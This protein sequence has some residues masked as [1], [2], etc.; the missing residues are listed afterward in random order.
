MGLLDLFSSPIHKKIDRAKGVMLN[1]HHQAQVRQGAIHELM[2]Y[3]TPAAIEALVE[4]LGVS[5]RDTIQNEHEQGWVHDL[6]VDHFKERAVEPLKDFIARG[7]FVSRAILT[8]KELISEEELTEHLRATL[9]RY[10]P[11]D[12]R[13]VTAR[14]NL[15]D[16]LGELAACPLRDLTPYTLDHS[17]DVR[18]KVMGIIEERLKGPAPAEE[19]AEVTRALSDVLLDPFS[20]G[21][22]TRAA[23]ALI[24]T[25]ALDLSPYAERLA[26]A[27]PDGLRI[28][29]GQLRAR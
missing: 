13:T 29:R 21:R 25:L 6:L 23:A 2:T 4:R 24:M 20:S 12:H 11:K 18:V 3:G 22:I 14:E 16:A 1:E 9:R 5:I 7:A 10:D 15:I 8:L 26:G 19:R 17:D 28:E 27:L